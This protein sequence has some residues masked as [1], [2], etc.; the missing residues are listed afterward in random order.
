VKLEL[1]WIAEGGSQAG[2]PAPVV[3]RHKRRESVAWIAAAVVT[4]AAQVFAFG[5]SQRTPSE[6]RLLRSFILPPEKTTFVTTGLQSGP[7]AVSPDG[8]RLAFT[9]E[10]SSGKHLLWVRSL[11]SVSAQ[12][13]A[14]T[15]GAS[16]PFWSPDSRYLGFFAGEKLKKVDGAGGPVLT[17]CDA[18]NGR[19]GSWSRDG[20]IV[21]TPAT[22][23][24]LLRISD[25]GGATTPATKLDESRSEAS[26]RWPYFLP[27]GRHF[28][29]L[30]RRIPS[31]NSQPAI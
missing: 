11:D 28:L 10:D 9:A 30:A 25:A 23:A 24:P 13:L 12:P 27:D 22:Y 14:G 26:H 31:V 2:V 16:F 1:K 18:P 5:Y 8:Q 4:L 3:A 20:I 7:V 15:E 17:L 6:E 21:F 19:G 29:Y